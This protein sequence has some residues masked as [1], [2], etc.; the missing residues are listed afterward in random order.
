MSL[1]LLGPEQAQLLMELLTP[2]GSVYDSS[3]AAAQNRLF[4][5]EECV[6][7]WGREREGLKRE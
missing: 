4:V 2:H 3:L 7:F 6:S 1:L 5:G